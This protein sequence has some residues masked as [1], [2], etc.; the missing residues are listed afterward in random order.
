MLLDLKDLLLRDSVEVREELRVV[1]VVQE[2]EVGEE[3]RLK[4]KLPEQEK[5]QLNEWEE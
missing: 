1:E 4:K 3:Y 5:R 2:E